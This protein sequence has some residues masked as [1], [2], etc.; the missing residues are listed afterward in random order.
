MTYGIALQA[1]LYALWPSLS[2]SLLK[3]ENETSVGIPLELEWTALLE[4][5][6]G[7]GRGAT[8][9]GVNNVGEHTDSS[10]ISPDNDDILYYFPVNVRRKYA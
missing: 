8:G 1:Y 2:G 10:S 6:G 5:G 7:G 3:L 9:G 4:N